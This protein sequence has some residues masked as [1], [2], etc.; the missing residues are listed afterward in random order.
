M[1]LSKESDR[2]AHLLRRFGLGASVQE[3]EFY[4]QKG[5]KGAIDLLLDDQRD[6]GIDLDI[7]KFASKN[8]AIKIQSVQM[9]WL[10]R[11]VLTKNPLKEKMALFWHDHFATSSQKVDSPTAMQ[12]QLE[13]FLAEGLGRFESLLL[14]VSKDPAMLY[15][16][17][18]QLNKKGKPNENFAREVMELFTLGIGHYTEKDVQEAARAFTGWGYGNGNRQVERVPNR[19]NKFLF[20]A[21]QHDDGIKMVLGNRGPWNGEEICGIL[22]GNPQTALAITKKIWEFFVYEKPDEALIKRLATLWRSNGFEMKVLLRAIME[23][24]EF[25]SEKS[26]R[27]LYKNPID[28]CIST[29]RQTGAGAI[30]RARI[31]EPDTDGDNIG[32]KIAGIQNCL[33]ATKAMGMEVLFPPDVAGWDWGSSWISSATMV[34]RMK[35][36]DRLFG[37]QGKALVEASFSDCNDARAIVSKLLTVLD[38]QLPKPKVDIVVAAAEKQAGKDITKSRQA[39]VVLASRLVFSSPEF[40]FC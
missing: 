6:D 7:A 11:M 39:V 5:V 26:A 32:R 1:Q 35:W 14:N 3:V 20:N 36:A 37:G 27:K 9:Y 17:D 12:N 28:F 31:S 24:P 30:L 8:G 40:Q 18:N 38:I 13:I 10:C 19:Q 21:A 16:L 34:E 4:G 25:Y 15:W 23:S 2:V 29:L 33:R 22:V